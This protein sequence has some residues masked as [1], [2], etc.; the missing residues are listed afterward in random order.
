MWMIRK[1]LSGSIE[2]NV[3]DANCA[4]MHVLMRRFLFILAMS[5]FL[6]ATYAGA[7]KFK[8]ALKPAQGML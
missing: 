4:W 3:T 2:R 5:T 6:G 8:D 1:E 7:E